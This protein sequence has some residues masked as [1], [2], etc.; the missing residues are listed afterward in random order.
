[1]DS[2]GIS[3]MCMCISVTDIY[4]YM[5]SESL[6]RNHEPRAKALSNENQIKAGVE[7]RKKKAWT[8][9][10]IAHDIIQGMHHT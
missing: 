7:K 10:C 1:M 3:R 5:L 6:I 9:I 2:A 8:K 4:I